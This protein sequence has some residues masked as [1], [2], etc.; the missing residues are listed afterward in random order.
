M[1][2]DHKFIMGLARPPKG[3][4]C[5]NCGSHRIRFEAVVQWC[6]GRQV[7]EIENVS[8]ALDCGECGSTNITF[9]RE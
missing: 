4:V 5:G 6:D 9:A 1:E 2:N 3:T 7:F 8:E